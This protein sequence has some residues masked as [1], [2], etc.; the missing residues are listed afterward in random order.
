MVTMYTFHAYTLLNNFVLD[1]LFNN[2][3]VSEQLWKVRIDTSSVAKGRIIH[4]PI[5]ITTMPAVQN[6]VRTIVLTKYLGP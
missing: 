5:I 6:S 4:S 1:C 2:V 3:C